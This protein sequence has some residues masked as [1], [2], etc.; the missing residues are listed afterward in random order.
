MFASPVYGTPY[1]AT[2]RLY[3]GHLSRLRPGFSPVEAW[4]PVLHR[5]LAGKIKGLVRP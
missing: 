3:I 2:G 4:P 5:L 1:E